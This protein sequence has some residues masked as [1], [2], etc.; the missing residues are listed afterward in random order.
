MATSP[1]WPLSSVPKVAFVESSIHE[2]IS[3]MKICPQNSYT[4][5]FDTTTVDPISYSVYLKVTNAA[6]DC[7]KCISTVYWRGKVQCSRVLIAKRILNNNCLSCSCFNIITICHSPHSSAN[8][9]NDT[10]IN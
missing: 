1:Q 4:W 3:L 5:K 7:F 9:N 10:H 2:K 6:P 8:K